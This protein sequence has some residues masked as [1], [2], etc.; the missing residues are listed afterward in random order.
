MLLLQASINFLI[1]TVFAI[2]QGF[3]FKQDFMVRETSKMEIVVVVLLLFTIRSY[4]VRYTLII[5]FLLITVWAVME[6]I[7]GT[8]RQVDT[9]T[10]LTN[11]IIYLISVLQL[12]LMMFNREMQ[13]RKQYNRDRII[14][15][16]IE[17][18]DEL[19]SKLVPL[20]VL[21]GL[22]NDERIVE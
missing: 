13:M 4:P 9:M 11:L 3:F 15:V 22:K 19:L 10:L 20:H 2:I 7:Y 6:V 8:S 14:D 5:M 16:E 1:S 18:N 17:K 12:I 21:R